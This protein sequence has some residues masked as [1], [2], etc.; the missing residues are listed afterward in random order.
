MVKE[1]DGGSF[2]PSRFNVV[3]RSEEDESVVLYNSMR[4]SVFKVRGHVGQKVHGLL[5]NRNA[6]LDRAAADD[7]QLFGTLV[8]KGFLVSVDHDEIAQADALRDERKGRTDRLELILMPTEACNFRCTYCYEDFALGRMLTEVRQGIRSLVERYHREHDISTLTVS[9][10]GGEPLVAL[11]VIEEL[12]EFFLEFC[13]AE[14][15]EYSA[16]ITTNG[17]LLTPDVAE[18]CARMGITHFQVTL[19][20]PEDTHDASRFLMGGGRTYGEIIDNLTEMAR[21][22]RRFKALIRTNFTQENHLRVPELIDQL[23]DLFAGDPRYRVIYRPVGDWGGPEAGGSS[24]FAGKEAEMA[25]LDLCSAAWEGGLSSAD[26]IFLKPNG[27]VCYAASPW[28]FVI[29][30]NGLVNKC[31]VA[32]RDPR[33]A[34]GQLD[35]D[36]DLNLDRDLMSLWVDNDDAKDQGC[37]S[38]FFRPSCQG[39]HCPLVRI[40]EGER[41]CPPQKVWIGPTILNATALGSPK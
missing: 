13:A 27:S 7:E 40:Q 37:R 4:G 1:V 6:V 22:D 5:S 12:S 21:T 16:G 34:V 19:D 20:G 8:D 30:P 38:C 9:W 25:K 11:D 31:T 41:P 14:G 2:T 24:A 28:S 10:F 23:S 33:N 32:L 17:L 35:G 26:S 39:A 18:R 29:R 3:T 36:G 15:I